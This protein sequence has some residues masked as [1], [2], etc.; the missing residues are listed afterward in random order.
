MLRL[1][2]VPVF[3]LLLAA[4]P[5]IAQQSSVPTMSAVA[6]AKAAAD[7][8]RQS[9]CEQALPALGEYARLAEQMASIIDKTLSP[10]DR[11][12]GDAQLRIRSTMGRELVPAQEQAS[13][14]R[15]GMHEALVDS[16]RCHLD[17]GNA[18]EA[19][20][21]TTL[22][23]EM[24]DGTNTALYRRVRDLHWEIIGFNSDL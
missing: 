20:E 5:T 18:A 7:A 9:G 2:T 16:A 23:L 11:A 17:G 14:L 6:A 3:A 8:A 15:E 21:I 4:S 19:L 12:V 22:V 24:L 13:A 1:L 10:F